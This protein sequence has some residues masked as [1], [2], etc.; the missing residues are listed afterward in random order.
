MGCASGDPGLPATEVCLP[1]TAVSREDIGG[2]DMKRERKLER[3]KESEE[4]R[5]KA[6]KNRRV[7]ERE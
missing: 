3:D 7:K 5:G 1:A 4:E 6:R 2:K